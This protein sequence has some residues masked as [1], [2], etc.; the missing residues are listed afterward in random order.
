MSGKAPRMTQPTQMVLRTLI[1]EPQ[2]E[3]HGI[4][5][6][7]ATGLAS[8]TVYPI[9][10][11]LEELGWLESR[12]EEPAVHVDEKRPR[13]RYYRLTGDGA[14]RARVALDSAGYRRRRASG[15][16]RTAGA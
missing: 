3:L 4:G 1:A 5:F 6:C 16:P 8:G 10:A 12:W 9:L 13:R 7:E 15:Q 2:R 11:R 14:V